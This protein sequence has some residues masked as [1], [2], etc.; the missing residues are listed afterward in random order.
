M[1]QARVTIRDVAADA[2]VSI[3]T[4]SHVLNQ[5]PGKRVS[6]ETRARVEASAAKL[7]YA[8]NAFAQ[9]LRTNRSGSIGLIGD[10]IATTPFAAR[11]ILGA[12]EAVQA[13]DSV[14]LIAT[15][16]YERA[17]EDR[18]IRE[19]VRRQVDG[20]LY[21][22]MYHREV[23]VPEAVRGVP[24]VVLNAFTADPSIP[25]V[26]PDEVGGARDAIGVLLDAGH[27]RI[28]FI[29]NEDDIPASRLRQ[30][31]VKARAIEGGL[32]AED[33]TI[34]SAEAMAAGGFEAGMSLLQQ[35][36]RPTAVF[37]FNDR[38]AM[39]VY[40]A[41]RV[42]GL[43]IPEDVSVVGFDDQEYVADGLY[44]ALTTIALPHY[45]MGRWAV[46]QLFERIEAPDGTVP[47]VHTAR[48]R[49]AVIRRDS[50]APP[51]RT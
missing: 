25:W 38:V 23:S 8:P 21:A 2:G 26:V 32:A 48:L 15:T 6:P 12:Q 36:G 31:G 40:R 27:R 42:L 16:G 51:P 45:E 30:A 4:V 28:G 3:T 1:G 7:G 17:V 11:I 13:H 50:V 44:P 10:E 43:R 49:G 34:V 37:C 39:G 20:I 18:E 14:L 19:L 24:V 33:L 41:A 46:D 29:N 5:V 9:S 22:A 35:P 47:T